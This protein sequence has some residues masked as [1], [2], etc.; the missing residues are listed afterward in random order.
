MEMHGQVRLRAFVD[1]MWKEEVKAGESWTAGI[2]VKRFRDSTSS[3]ALKQGIRA[4]R[5]IRHLHFVGLRG[6]ES[7]HS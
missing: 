5:L 4:I 6:S 7:I 3:G 1:V 2:G